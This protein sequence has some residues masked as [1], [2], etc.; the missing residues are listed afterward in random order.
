MTEQEI[1]STIVNTAATYIGT[2]TG[3]SKHQE[4]IEGYNKIRDNAPKMY[5]S[6]AWCAAFISYI[7]DKCGFRD[8]VGVECNCGT[9][10]DDWVKMGIWEE[11]DDYFPSPGDI[12]VFYWNAK[13]TGDCT[14]HASHVGF[15]EKCDG[16]YIYTIEGNKGTPGICDKRKIS[17]NHKW[18]RGFCVPNYKSKATEEKGVCEVRVRELKKGMRGV[19]VRC[20]MLILKDMGYYK[21][22]VTAKDKLFGDKMDKAV[23]LFQQSYALPVTGILDNATWEWILKSE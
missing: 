11:K 14:E 2:K 1:R 9:F 6:S 4:I 13:E 20:A 12:I 19:D 8:L 10:V 18:I 16:K 17:V 5:S 7:I 3:S 22:V 23:R 15:V 21:G